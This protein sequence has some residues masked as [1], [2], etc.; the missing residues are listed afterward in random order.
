VCVCVSNLG[1]ITDFP[2]SGHARVEPQ[3]RPRL[4]ASTPSAIHSPQLEAVHSEIL[5]ESLNESWF[6]KQMTPSHIVV[7]AKL[8]S[9]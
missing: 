6:G 2:D 1:R 8:A 9:S 4:F 7:S 3:S 5:T